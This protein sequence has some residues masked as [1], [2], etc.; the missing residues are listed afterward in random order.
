M[1]STLA[2]VAAVRNVVLGP[3][4]DAKI[5]ACVTEQLWGV[6]LPSMFDTSH[7]EWTLSAR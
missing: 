6:V 3:R 4:R 1:E 7:S 5:E 2:E